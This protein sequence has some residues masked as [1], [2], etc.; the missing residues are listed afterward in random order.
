MTSTEE[1]GYLPETSKQGDE[2]YRHYQ[3]ALYPTHMQGYGRCKTR[4]LRPSVLYLVVLQSV[5]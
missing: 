2:P 4:S 5:S 3:G 1:S